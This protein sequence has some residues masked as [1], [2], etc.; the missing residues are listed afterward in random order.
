[1]YIED[2]FK[3]VTI[4]DLLKFFVLLIVIWFLIQTFIYT[5]RTIRIKTWKPMLSN[6][7]YEIKNVS[8][9]CIVDGYV[10]KEQG[11]KEHYYLEYKSVETGAIKKRR[12]VEV[13]TYARFKAYNVYTRQQSELIFYTPGLNN[14]ILRY[15]MVRTNDDGVNFAGNF[16]E[17]DITKKIVSSAIEHFKKQKPKKY[18]YSTSLEKQYFEKKLNYLDTLPTVA[19]LFKRK[20]ISNDKNK[21][22]EQGT[23]E[24]INVPDK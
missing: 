13:D 14:K 18:I 4:D 7:Y 6:I 2:L 23:A 15:R 16:K 11:K 8:E 22:R 20:R 10:M 1:M 17:E 24:K 3:I 19:D 5:I 21:V 12:I 9:R